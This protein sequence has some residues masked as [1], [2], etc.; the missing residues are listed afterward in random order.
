M[1][2]EQIVLEMLSYADGCLINGSNKEC[3]VSSGGILCLNDEALF[4]EASDLI[5]LYSGRST[6]I[7]Q[8]TQAMLQGMRKALATGFRDLSVM[9]TLSIG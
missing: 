4:Y 9:T 2:I 5:M 1:P 7:D 6:S 8:E 3:M